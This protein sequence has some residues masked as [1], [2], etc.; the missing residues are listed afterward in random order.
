MIYTH[1]IFDKV[2]RI[3]G[4]IIMGISI[5]VVGAVIYQWFIEAIIAYYALFFGIIWIAFGAFLK[6]YKK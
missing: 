1:P 4:D 6:E 2:I 3:I 5:S